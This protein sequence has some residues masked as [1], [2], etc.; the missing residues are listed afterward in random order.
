MIRTHDA[1]T[2]NRPSAYWSAGV[3]LSAYPG[4]MD[5]WEERM[6]AKAKARQVVQEAEEAARRAADEAAARAEL[7]AA[8][9]AV[10]GEDEV[11]IALDGIWREHHGHRTH[12]HFGLGTMCSCGAMLGLASVVVHPDDPPLPPCPVC[13]ARGIG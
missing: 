2:S 12:A 4:A 3:L 9:P 13:M 1:R 11:I 8:F 10:P 6:S 5:T 7:D